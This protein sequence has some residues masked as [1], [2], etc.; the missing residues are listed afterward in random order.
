MVDPCDRFGYAGEQV[1]VAPGSDIT[2]FRHLFVQDAVTVKEYRCQGT[3]SGSESRVGH[4]AMI[5]TT[6]LAWLVERPRVKHSDGERKNSCPALPIR[7][8][9]LALPLRSI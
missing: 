8:P 6:K 7:Q 3:R 1:E 4:E 9:S 2:P 5:T